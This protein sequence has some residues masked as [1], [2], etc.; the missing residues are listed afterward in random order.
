[1]VI[2]VWLGVKPTS[3]VQIEAKRD[4]HHSLLLSYC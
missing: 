2:M 4:S 1:M 3:Q